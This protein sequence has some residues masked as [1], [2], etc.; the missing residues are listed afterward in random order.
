MLIP[1][2]SDRHLFHDAA[3]HWFVAHDAAYATCALT[4]G[5]LL[6]L[7]IREGYPR[8]TAMESLESI[9]AHQ[10][11]EFWS[12]DH[13]FTRGMLK[14]VVGHRQVTDAY[15]AQQ[16]RGRGARIATFDE[17]LAALHP[18]VADLVSS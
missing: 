1:L 11:H 9:T 7:L 5:A 18:D 6:R 14:G 16:A 15:L 13:P 12:A 17:G 8:E 4:Q 3:R 10:H 2:A